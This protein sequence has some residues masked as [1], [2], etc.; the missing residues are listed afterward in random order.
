MI[1]SVSRRTDIPAL[2]AEWFINR[3]HEQFVYV[4]N[5]FNKNAISRISLA[6]NDVDCLVFW[7]KNPEPLIQYLPQLCAYP[8]YVLCTITGYGRDIEHNVPSAQTVIESLCKLSD[9]IGK[10]RT[11]W[12]YDP[13]LIS[14]TCTVE[15]H[16]RQFSYILSC[17][18]SKI[19][20]CVISFF[21][22]YDSCKKKIVDSSVREPTIEEIEQIAEHFSQLAKKYGIKIQTCAEQYDLEKYGIKHGSCIDGE[23]IEQ[24]TGKKVQARKDTYQRSLCQCVESVDIG[25]YN[26]CSHDCVYCYAN[27]NIE[28]A[29]QALAN[30]NPQSPLLIGAVLSTDIIRNRK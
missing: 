18:H 20:T 2:Y 26:T 23:L 30:H 24:I 1:I 4:R 6:P 19:E 10:K 3:L 21:D 9:A 17:L 16:I 5:P 14:N 28:L 7:T 25:E 29:K 22:Y 12:R 15:Y 8:F 13:I 27:K 11:I